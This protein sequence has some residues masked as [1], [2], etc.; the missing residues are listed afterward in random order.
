MDGTSDQDLRAMKERI[1]GSIN[2]DFQSFQER[3]TKRFREASNMFG[4]LEADINRKLAEYETFKK[5]KQDWEENKT[6]RI[7]GLNKEMDEWKKQKMSAVQ[8]EV[9][10]YMKAEKNRRVEL[11]AE[12]LKRLGAEYRVELTKK[13]DA[14]IQKKYAEAALDAQIYLNAICTDV[15]YL[16]A[17]AVSCIDG[18]SKLATDVVEEVTLQHAEAA[19]ILRTASAEATEKVEAATTQAAEILTAASAEAA[20]RVAEAAKQVE[21]ASADVT[22]LRA[23]SDRLRAEHAEIRGKTGGLEQMRAGLQAEVDVLRNTK[24]EY[25]A[26][27]NGLNAD[28]QK[29]LNF[30][31]DAAKF[32]ETLDARERNLALRESLLVAREAALTPFQTSG[33]PSDAMPPPRGVQGGSRICPSPV[34]HLIVSTEATA[35]LAAMME[36]GGD[37]GGGASSGDGGSCGGGGLGGGSGLGGGGGG[38]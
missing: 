24:N 14:E 13:I 23:E 4:G 38:A 28:Y 17:G 12:D 1:F 30:V 19:E 8:E 11:L 5:E 25:I 27:N 22:A 26:R 2:E 6:K 7:D 18:M 10:S 29:A 37:G 32:K 21:A 36:S 20:K 31:T 34:N 16:R 9:D 3:M 35:R 33:I 15:H